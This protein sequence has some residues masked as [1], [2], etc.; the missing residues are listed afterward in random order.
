MH[1]VGDEYSQMFKL[2]EVD[3]EVSTDEE[4]SNV[5]I[6]Y[7]EALNKLDKHSRYQLLVINRAVPENLI[8]QTL[9]PYQADKLDN[10]RE[11]INEII[12][13]QY[14]KDER[15]FQVDKYAIFTTASHSR[16]QASKNLVTLAS[17]YVTQFDDNEV[18]LSVEKISGLERLKVMASL[19]KPDDYFISTYEDIAVSGLSSK[20]FISP[21]KMSFPRGRVFFKLGEKYGAILYIKQYP[22]YLED[23]LIRE[24]TSIGRE[25]VISIHARPY[26]MKEAKKK[27]QAVS[28]RNE[29][30]IA[31][32]Q[33]RNFK[34]GVSEDMVSGEA[35]EIKESTESLRKQFKEDGQ[36]LFSGIFTVM[37]LEDDEH[38][39]KQAIQDVK[40]VGSY[41]DVYFE[42]IEDYKTEALN[43]ILPIGKPYLDVEMNYMRDMTSFNV[44]TQIPFSKGTITPP[45]EIKPVPGSTLLPTYFNNLGGNRIISSNR[46]KSTG[47]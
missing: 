9:L 6:G 40:D 23:T 43:T 45:A 32:Q 16:K 26:D 7:A 46:N 25:S 44:A 21:S 42:T 10:Y 39:L 18:D 1:I 30:E 2:G 4:Q 8:D 37:V 12:Q 5:V 15:N 14:E 34:A 31:K 28:I 19:L 41:H 20:A 3:Y 13:Q 38:S 47:F 29:T 27:V 24:I 11:E 17:N 22:K 33:K 36:K 35:K